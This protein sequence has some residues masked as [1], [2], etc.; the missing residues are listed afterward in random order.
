MQM[1][2]ASP[3]RRCVKE[4]LGWGRNRVPQAQKRSSESWNWDG[5][6]RPL[7]R[8]NLRLTAR[9]GEVCS[10]EDYQG[11]TVIDSDLI[12]DAEE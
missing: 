12:E 8:T 5:E 4:E 1:G 7:V 3:G 11:N 2:A 6:N 9:T 10:S